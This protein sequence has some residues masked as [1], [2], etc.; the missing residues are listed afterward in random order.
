MDGKSMWWNPA[1][2][3]TVGS[4]GV[5]MADKVL[6]GAVS[7]LDKLF[8]TDEEK[9]EFKQNA[10]KMYLEHQ[11]I[12]LSENTARSITRRILAVMIIG[13]FLA[14]LV[15]AVAI[16]KYNSAWAAFTLKV[17]GNLSTGFG[18]IIVFYYGYYAV[19]NL[20]DKRKGKD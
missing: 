16:W 17:A 19:G 5:D 13:V 8:F 7:G 20:M 2:W 9:A 6:D 15:F 12:I 1:S 4:K 11:K 14:G 10:G 18:A 3:F